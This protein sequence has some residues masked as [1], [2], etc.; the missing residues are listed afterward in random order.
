M[1]L[2]VVIVTLLGAASIAAAAAG[3]Y[4]AFRRSAPAHPVPVPVTVARD[5]E[6]APQAAATRD[7]ALVD[8]PAERP[9]KTRPA[10]T[11]KSTPATKTAEPTIGV[12]VPN[13]GP[14]SPVDPA[15]PEAREAHP[16]PA[17][18]VETPRLHEVTVASDSVI[19]IR[20]ESTLSSDTSRV[21]DKVAA[22]VT[23]D[24]VV[25]RRTAISAGARLEG[26]V[27]AVEHAGKFKDRARLGVRFQSIVLA[28][29]TRL[30]IE[31]ETIFREGASPA[32]SATSKVGA[33]A[34]IGGILGAVIGGKKGAA[35]GSS[36]GAAGGTAAVMAGAAPN[37]VLQAGTPLTVRLTAPITVAVERQ[38]NN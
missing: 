35:I 11:P 12:P 7:V 36:F 32:G 28:G 6:P 30:P 23:R 16:D 3:G 21:E 19:G 15:V 4:V 13:S 37:V 18:V 14:P 24:V 1:S 5:A 29:G 38:D 10:E 17:P 33:S 25:D 2:K 20:L 27:S 22:R 31:T 34:A 9:A 26:V 8:P